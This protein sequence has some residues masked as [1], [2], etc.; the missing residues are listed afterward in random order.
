[1][2]L[3]LWSHSFNNTHLFEVLDIYFPSVDFVKRLLDSVSDFHLDVVFV[4]EVNWDVVQDCVTIGLGCI[5]S[6]GGN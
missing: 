3:S 1:M 2:F 4:P 6:V 5:S